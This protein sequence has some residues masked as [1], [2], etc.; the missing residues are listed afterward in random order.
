MKDDLEQ[1]KRLKADDFKAFEEVVVLY[2]KQLVRFAKRWL[3]ETAAEDVVQE[4]FYKLYVNRK[5]IKPELGVKNYLYSICRNEAMQWFRKN[6]QTLPLFENAEEGGDLYLELERKMTFDRVRQA[7]ASLNETKKGLVNMHFFE[8]LGYSE[9][10]EK[11]KMPI[12]TI[13]TNIRRAK[14]ELFKKLKKYE[15]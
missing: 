6:K 14:I 9:I 1:I 4:S 13:K 8:G 10:S 15:R 11:M 5:R 12:S 3:E 2:E 7:V